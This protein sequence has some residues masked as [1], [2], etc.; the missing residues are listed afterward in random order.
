MDVKKIPQHIKD[1]LIE[2]GH[3]E[4]DMAKM[5]AERAFHEFCEWHGLHDWAPILLNA[6]DM[7]READKVSK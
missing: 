6:L 1:D 4:E 5:S 2:R 3:T 7:L